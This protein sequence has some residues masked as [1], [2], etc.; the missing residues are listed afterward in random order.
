MDLKLITHRTF[1]AQQCKFFRMYLVHIIE[2]CLLKW[3]KSQMSGIQNRLCTISNAKV[4]LSDFRIQCFYLESNKYLCTARIQMGCHNFIA[5]RFRWQAFFPKLSFNK[6][7]YHLFCSLI[8]PHEANKHQ[9]RNITR[10]SYSFFATTIFNI[11][12]YL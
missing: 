9:R 10:L 3:A 4:Q 1:S 6:F 5:N 11:S 12:R 7:K 2:V 8:S